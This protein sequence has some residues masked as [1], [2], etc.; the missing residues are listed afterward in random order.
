MR[1]G[2]TPAKLKEIAARGTLFEPNLL[3]DSINQTIIGL[4]DIVVKQHEDIMELKQSLSKTRSDLSVSK[5]ELFKMNLHIEEIN[6]KDDVTRILNRLTSL[7]EST[8]KFKFNMNDT[9]KSIQES[10]EKMVQ[11]NHDVE[12]DL[13]FQISHLTPEVVGLPSTFSN[14]DDQ[15]VIIDHNLVDVSPLIRGLYRDSRRIDGIGE[16]ISTIRME[17]E[18]VVNAVAAAQDN[19]QSFNHNLHDMGLS[20]IKYKTLQNER[21]SYFQSSIR[22]IEKQISEIWFYLSAVNE[23]LH[24]GLSNTMQSFDEIQSILTRLSKLPLPEI[25]S[26]ADVYVECTN[27]RENLA[28]KKVQFEGERDNFVHPPEDRFIDPTIED[29]GVETIRNT[30]KYIIGEK[31]ESFK[32]KFDESLIQM[33]LEDLRT[34]VNELTRGSNDINSKF[35]ELTK[36]TQKSIDD[37]ADVITMERLFGKY[38]MLLDKVSQKIEEFESM[39]GK[40]GKTSRISLNYNEP[41]RPKKKKPHFDELPMMPKPQPKERPKSTV[42]AR[43]YGTEP[44][45]PNR[46]ITVSQRNTITSRLACANIQHNDFA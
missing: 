17:N 12:D 38:Q 46:A 44:P 40:K 18:N 5:T 42:S 6:V 14:E 22:G 10:I 27:N 25:T 34:R 16:T 28:E 3:P 23:N 30:T 33:N 20:M 2:F 15:P 45:N 41:I 21:T 36:A 35:K 4:C 7:E 13:R 37:K 24:H 26:L 11:K 29:V 39:S 43:I 8:K 32:Q 31:V 19:L 9:T 1:P